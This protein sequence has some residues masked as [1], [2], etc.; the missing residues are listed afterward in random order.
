MTGLK[1]YTDD[2]AVRDPTDE[3]SQAFVSAMRR[4]AFRGVVV[5]ERA[6]AARDRQVIAALMRKCAAL[7]RR[8]VELQ[9]ELEQQ[10]RNAP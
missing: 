7:E 1:V 3:E 9:G 6:R 5:E 2:G 10:R 8:V 4:N